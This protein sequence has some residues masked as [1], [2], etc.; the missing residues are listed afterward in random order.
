MNGQQ[1]SKVLRTDSLLFG[2]RNKQAI[3]RQAKLRSLF[4]PLKLQ[5]GRLLPLQNKCQISKL[6]TIIQNFPRLMTDLSLNLKIQIW[7]LLTIR[8]R[9]DE[10]HHSI[11]VSENRL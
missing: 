4:P 5:I 11:N 9:H 1:H 10:T 2:Q 3:F 7:N 8:E 6:K